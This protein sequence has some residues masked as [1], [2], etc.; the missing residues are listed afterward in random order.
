MIIRP[1]WDAPHVRCLP[2]MFC[3]WPCLLRQV[4]MV[5]GSPCDCIVTGITYANPGSRHECIHQTRERG[6]EGIYINRPANLPYIKTTSLPHQIRVS[7]SENCC[8]PLRSAPKFC[9]L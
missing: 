3:A 6:T 2:R 5:L 7:L 4:G 9:P 1:G 8:H